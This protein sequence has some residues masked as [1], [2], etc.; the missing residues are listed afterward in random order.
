VTKYKLRYVY[1][2]FFMNN[3]RNSFSIIEDSNTTFFLI[4][5]NSDLIHFFISLIV[6]RSIN[7]NFIKYF[8][9]PR[10]VCNLFISKSNLVF[11]K[12]PFLLF[13]RFNSTNIGVGSEKNMLKRSFLLIYFFNSFFLLHVGVKLK[14]IKI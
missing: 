14:F 5:I 3:N 8:V 2:V 7:K 9:E 1:F 11:R 6:I 13:G 12:D 4:D 10:S